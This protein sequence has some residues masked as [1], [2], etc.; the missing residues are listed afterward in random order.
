MITLFEEGT[1]Q[2]ELVLLV[3]MEVVG[4]RSKLF[5]SSPLPIILLPPQD[6]QLLQKSLIISWCTS[7]G[8]R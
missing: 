4:S 7:H 1:T 3:F 5:S 2:T 8:F 6:L